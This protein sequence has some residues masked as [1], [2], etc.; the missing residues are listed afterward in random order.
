MHA[1][2]APR[3]QMTAPAKPGSNS[4][5]RPMDRAR[6]GR[7]FDALVRGDDGSGGAEGQPQSTADTSLAKA[8][9]QAIRLHDMLDAGNA[10]TS[11]LV[12]ETAGDMAVAAPLDAPVPPSS[13]ASDDPIIL[14]PPADLPPSEEAS[15]TA[16]AG[17]DDPVP[18]NPAPVP[19]AADSGPML[20][21]LD[22]LPPKDRDAGDDAID[23]AAP[24]GPKKTDK[25]VDA[26]PAISRPHPT[27]PSAA[28]TPHVDTSAP[29]VAPSQ[30]A[31]HVAWTGA[32]APLSAT[33]DMASA[34]ASPSPPPPVAPSGRASVDTLIP[35][36][37]V[38]IARNAA[39][40]REEFLLRLRPADHGTIVV[41][42]Q[43][44]GEGPL[45]ATIS[46][47]NM[48][49]LDMLRRDSDALASNLSDAG[50]QTDARSFRFSG[51]EGG[52]KDGQGPRVAWG[53]S[54]ADRSA[55]DGVDEATTLY[56]PLRAR[57]GLVNR[58]A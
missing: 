57:A 43:F 58:L 5:D 12:A 21:N 13:Q 17:A 46:A 34:A 36:M 40:G 45:R 29:V 54:R 44:L 53:A 2:Q 11:P 18:G 1:S 33:G 27:I 51:G 8:N 3:P 47:D 31:P 49:V 32:G 37:A 52:Q 56:R 55:D 9:P 20:A 19:V 41:R 48:A 16:K 10:A 22:P 7:D 39:I 25:P 26:A 23:G 42:L 14:L 4:V 24:G 50:V 30:P 38:E 6:E 28:T 35:D 15:T